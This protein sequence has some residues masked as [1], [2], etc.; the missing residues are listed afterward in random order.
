MK[1]RTPLQEKKSDRF[2]F[3]DLREQNY[4]A[5]NE[6]MLLAGGYDCEVKGTT[7]QRFPPRHPS[8]RPKSF[9]TNLLVES[10]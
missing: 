8:L 6:E 5:H 3:C 9:T 10:T 1:G 4:F 7:C 2:K